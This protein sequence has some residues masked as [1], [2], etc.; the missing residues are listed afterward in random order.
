MK[1]STYLVIFFEVLLEV[2]DVLMIQI[3]LNIDFLKNILSAVQ[4]HLVSLDSES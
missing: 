4:T 3:T 1:I 2:N